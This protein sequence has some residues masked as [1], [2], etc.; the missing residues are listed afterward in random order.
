M[1]LFI[2]TNKKHDKVLSL[3]IEFKLSCHLH[4][5]SL[6]VVLSANVEIILMS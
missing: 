4:E 1:V 5:I 6:F 2:A 3:I